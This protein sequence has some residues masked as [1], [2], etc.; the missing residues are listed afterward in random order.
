VSCTT[1]F[2]FP[3]VPDVYNKNMVSSEFIISGSQYESAF[4]NSSSKFRNFLPF[5]FLPILFTTIIFLIVVFFAAFFAFFSKF[6][7]FPLRKYPSA[8]I[9][10]FALPSCILA[11][12]AS[13]ENALNTTE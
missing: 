13:A 9:S 10:I 8:V 6:S 3:V 11:F 5:T 4:S 1:P 7:G 2:G 12:S